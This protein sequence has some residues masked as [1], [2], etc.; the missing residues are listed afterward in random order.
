MEVRLEKVL[1][2]ITD[3]MC[4]NPSVSMRKLATNRNEEVQF[5]RFMCNE[6]F[7]S[8]DMVQTMYTTTRQNCTTPHCLLIEDTSQIGFSL[9]RSIKNLGKLDKGQVQGFYLH[10][11]LALDAVDYGCI[12][13]AS[14]E[15]IFRKWE[16]TKITSEEADKVK[17]KTAFEDK[18]SY[19]WYRSIESS[20]P[21][22]I[23]AA[24]KTVVADREADTYQLFTGFT[25]VL[26]VDFVVRS[27]GDRNVENNIRL[28]QAV[29]NWSEASCHQQKV[30]ATDG[31]SA[32][33]AKL[34]VKFGPIQLKKSSGKAHRIQ[35]KT[36][37]L[38]V[39]DVNEMPESVVNNEKPIHW[40][41]ITS[42][43]VETVEMALQIIEWYKQRWTIEQI[44]RTLK[45]KGL[46]IEN[47]L[48]DD[49]DKLKKLTIMALMSAVKVMQL[50][51]A[52]DGGTNQKIDT[53][54]SED[55]Q[56]CLIALNKKLEGKTEK[57]KNPFPPNKLAF[58]SWVIAR[59]T[60]WSG[61]TSQRQAGPIDFMIGLQRFYQ[62]FE[63]Y[64]MAKM[65]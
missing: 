44:F 62:R 29:K 11:V 32:H 23:G 38:Y 36:L 10:P 37:D 20:L 45:E 55:E 65:E 59:L 1:D 34:V 21:Q 3:Q 46:R 7:S 9:D 17:K 39:V 14:S 42:H 50:I 40:L 57:L 26:H 60:G 13:I 53:C 22:C 28:L 33:T 5:S 12:G 54:F 63:G 52:R 4:N 61:Y 24:R 16:E 18:E 41:L 30:P 25:E 48:L 6:S 47:S 2:N 19:R 27:R 56:K 51:K 58:A 15:F 8:D 35:P 64:M 31:R 49:Y 43:V